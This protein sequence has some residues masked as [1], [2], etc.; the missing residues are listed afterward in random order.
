LIGAGFDGANVPTKKF[1]AWNMHVEFYVDLPADRD[2]AP[3][4][5]NLAAQSGAGINLFVASDQVRFYRDSREIA[6][7][8]V[9]AVVYSEV[10]RDVDL[11]TSVCA[12]GD[13]ERWLDQGDRGIGVL[14]RQFD[15]QEVSAVIAL[16]AE[17]LTRVLP[18]MSVGERC[19]I[20]KSWLE[21]R[22]NLGTYRISLGWDVAGLAADTGMRWLKIPRMALDAVVLDLA[23]VPIELDHRTETILR[24]AHVLADDWKI[25][26]PELVR[27][28]MPE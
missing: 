16:R 12:V 21:V 15:M 19:K 26:L 9:P 14:T 8:E 25:D 10:M 5:S 4:A 7:D 3:R 13:D 20:Q 23:D 6:V 17:I 18:H 11:F 1:E 24:K 2:N 27:Q 28:L 22:G